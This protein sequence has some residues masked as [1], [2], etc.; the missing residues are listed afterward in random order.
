MIKMAEKIVN[1]ESNQTDSDEIVS[2]LRDILKELKHA[3]KQVL[4]LIP[5]VGK[6]EPSAD[7]VRIGIVSNEKEQPKKRGRPKKSA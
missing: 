6:P 1:V 4:R 5:E 2:L 3:N 7:N